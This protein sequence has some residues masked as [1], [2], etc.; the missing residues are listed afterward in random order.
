MRFTFTEDQRLLRDG[1]ADFLA[2]ECTP[3][4]VRAAWDETTGWSTTRW[5]G[6]ASL[7]V[8]GLTAPEQRGGLGLDETSLVLVC[9]QAGR[10]AL[11]EPLIETTAVAIPLL[12]EVA[13][14]A[15]AARWLPALAA[16]EASAAVALPGDGEAPGYVTNAAGADLVLMADH[17]AVHLLTPAE[18]DFVGVAAID[19]AQRLARVSATPGRATCLTDAPTATEAIGRAADRGA[20]AAAAQLVGIGRRVLELAAHYSTQREQFGRPIGSFQAVK[21]H[22]ASALVEVEYARPAVYRAADSVARDTAQR[23]RDVS[24]AK[25]LAGE[26]AQLACRTAL[27]VHGAIGYTWEH[28]LHLWMKK[29]WGL[30]AAWGTT[31]HHL[32][33]VARAA[34]DAP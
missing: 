5:K 29:A 8:V 21:H 26:A 10:A 14:D 3:A 6:L 15:V 4:H 20:L 13:P 1:V 18:A 34:V 24:M 27:Q 33:R 25:V 31:D 30:V 2:G 9:E 7:G 19:P 16:G 12:A 17:G 28:D 22:L 32:E 11:P 23:A